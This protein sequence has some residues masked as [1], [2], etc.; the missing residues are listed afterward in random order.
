MC[1]IQNTHYT[2]S[3]SSISHKPGICTNHI[4]HFSNF[5]SIHIA[6]P[7]YHT[8]LAIFIIIIPSHFSK[9]VSKG[10]RDIHLCWCALNKL[11]KYFEWLRFIFNSFRACSVSQTSQFSYIFSILYFWLNF[12][13]KIHQKHFQKSIENRERNKII[14]N[15]KKWKHSDNVIIITRLSLFSTL[16]SSQFFLWSL[17]SISLC[18]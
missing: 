6:C 2:F 16:P 3:F 11:P 12:R 17:P 9:S 14:F 7:M 13:K 5:T 18:G 4:M 15:V 1:P 10:N 8:M